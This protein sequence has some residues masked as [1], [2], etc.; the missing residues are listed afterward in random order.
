MEEELVVL[1]SVEGIVRK[2]RSRERGGRYRKMR[3][4]DK[5]IEG[6]KN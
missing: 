5:G 4:V 1:R 2:E 3:E 6:M